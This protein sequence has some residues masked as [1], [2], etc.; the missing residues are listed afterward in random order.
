[1]LDENR[2]C[3]VQIL[4]HRATSHRRNPVLFRS[5]STPA[6]NR[7]LRSR[8]GRS[9]TKRRKPT[10]SSPTYSQTRLTRDLGLGEYAILYRYH[11]MGRD[12][13]ERLICAGLPCRLA[14]GQALLDDE[15][16][17][18][19]IAS[20]RVIRCPDDPTLQGAL[21]E[22]AFP[23]ALRQEVRKVSSRERDLLANLR[24]F[25]ASPLER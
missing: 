22:R 20:L 25:A 11:K 9:R 6:A 10:G 15:V 21:A 1:M 7:R 18:W 8:R 3:S 16:V 14:R 23:G 13:E 5:R 17:G 4:E 19:V 12:L 2:R 24:A